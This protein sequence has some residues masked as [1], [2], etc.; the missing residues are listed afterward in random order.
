MIERKYALSDSLL[1]EWADINSENL[2]KDIAKFQEFDPQEFPE[3]LPEMIEQ[4]VTDAL[5]EGGDSNNKALLG[6]KTLTVRQAIQNCKDYLKDLKYWVKKAYPDN[7]VI[8]RQLGVNR[9]G[10]I[11][12]T[13]PRLIQF[14]ENLPGVIKM[15]RTRFEEVGTP[16]DLLDKSAPLSK[17][18]RQAN[19]DQEKQKG[20]RAID[21]EARIIHLNSLYDLLQKLNEAAESVFKN[22]PVRRSRY[23]VPKSGN[24]GSDTDTTDTPKI[25]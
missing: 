12:R 5:I 6:T 8:Q 3:T 9:I 25:S 18:L 13:Q 21:T 24:T 7:P 20:D 4:R 2:T 22:E 14:M 10:S 23:K 15:H 1:L 11:F 19:K 17:A 16:V